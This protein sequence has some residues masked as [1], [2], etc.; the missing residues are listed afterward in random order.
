[1]NR[2]NRLGKAL[3]IPKEVERVGEDID[4]NII[5][6]DNIV[7]KNY[8]EKNGLIGWPQTGVAMTNGLGTV[9]IVGQQKMEAEKFGKRG[10][11]EE[12]HSF[13]FSSSDG[14]KDETESS[15]DFESSWGLRRRVGTGCKNT[16]GG[17]ARAAVATAAS[18]LPLNPV[19]SMAMKG[20][21]M[22]AEVS[23]MRFRSVQDGS[24]AAST[25]CDIT[26]PI[27]GGPIAIVRWMNVVLDPWGEFNS[28]G[29]SEN[30]PIHNMESSMSRLAHREALKKRVMM[31]CGQVGAKTDIGG[32]VELVLDKLSKDCVAVGQYVVRIY[33]FSI[34]PI[35]AFIK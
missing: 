2:N 10:E 25:P 5:T 11:S 8:N 26:Y 33:I 12:R 28:G 31:W 34:I 20:V 27:D 24:C 22:S 13:L 21:G 3:R 15:I 14:G 4:S 32:P 29:S 17:G 30:I 7:I 19:E 35:D 6:D 23:S 16:V 1:M 18:P 9:A